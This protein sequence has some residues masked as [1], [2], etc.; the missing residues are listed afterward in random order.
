MTALTD[1]LT[2]TKYQLPNSQ[3]SLL[4]AVEEICNGCRVTD[5]DRRSRVL[6][7]LAVSTG[8]L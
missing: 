8:V 6:D 3:D 5:D 1:H 4:S 7:E 2:T